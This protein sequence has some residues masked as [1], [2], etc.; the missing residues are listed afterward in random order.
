MLQISVQLGLVL[1]VLVTFL[2]G[3]GLAVVF[4]ALRKRRRKAR[5]RS[6]IGIN[7]LRSPGHTVRERLEEQSHDLMSEVYL[8]SSIPLTMLALFLAQAHVR[9]LSNMAHLIPVYVVVVLGFV[10][11]FVWRVLKAGER[12]DRLRAGFD[13]EL[14]VGQELDQLMRQGAVVFHDFPAE[15]F[16]IDHI[17]IA[18]QGVFAVET[19]G[20]TKRTDISGRAAATVAFDGQVLEFPTWTTSEPLQQA[21]RQAQWL[22][23]WA[24]SALGDSSIKVT[25]VLA[26]PGWFVKRAGR[27]PV[28]VLS[29]R[30]LGRLLGERGVQAISEQDVQRLAHQVEQRCRTVV[31]TDRQSAGVK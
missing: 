21:E 27:G 16:N 24:G 13:A 12:L 14:A 30:E 25:P 9:G 18:H 5:R 8:L 4:L 2:L 23:Q 17:V 19:K 26:L 10:A 22:T 31:P 6:P 20:Y 28:R 1:G 29:G 3:P 15:N 11:C 7:L